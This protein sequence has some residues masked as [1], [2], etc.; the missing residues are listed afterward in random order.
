[1]NLIER[2]LKDIKIHSFYNNI[3]LEILP[4]YK[5]DWAIHRCGSVRELSYE[6]LSFSPQNGTEQFQLGA[7][8][9]CTGID[10]QDEFVETHWMYC[11]QV[12][13]QV[14]LGIA[15]NYRK[16]GMTA[17]A[18]ILDKLFPSL[19]PLENFIGISSDPNISLGVSEYRLGGSGNLISTGFGVPH[20]MGIQIEEPSLPAHYA[21]GARN[22]MI[23]A[24][25]QK[26]KQTIALSN[27]VCIQTNSLAIFLQEDAS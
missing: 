12:L 7:T 14:T 10:E 4:C 15:H 24:T 2:A 26:T 20:A 27:L 13:P 8:Y 19:E 5:A 3:S 6:S 25:S 22:L 21:T 1:M 16:P 17:P 23:S 18:P 9:F 11:T